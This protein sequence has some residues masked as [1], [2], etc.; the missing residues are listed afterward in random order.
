MSK[1]DGFFEVRHNVIFERAWFNRRTHRKGSSL[2]STSQLALYTLIETCEFRELKEEML[3]D[4]I[5]VGI[6][7]QTL[8]KC[9][10]TDAK[11]TLEKAKRV[12]CQKAVQEQHHIL[13]GDGSTKSPLVIDKVRGRRSAGAVRGGAVRGTTDGEAQKV[14]EKPQCRRC[15]RP[16]Q[17]DGKCELFNDLDGWVLLPFQSRLQQSLIVVTPSH[18]RRITWYGVTGMPLTWQ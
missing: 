2:N 17:I 5:V 16:H 11:L 6:Q 18:E 10:Q 1:L 3:H 14:E 12:V 15:S 7:D 13:Q 4:Q 9:L 8:S